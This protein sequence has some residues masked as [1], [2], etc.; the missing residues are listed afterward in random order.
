MGNEVSIKLHAPHMIID[1][2][3]GNGVVLNDAFMGNEVVLTAER[4]GLQ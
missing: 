3:K 1:A 4:K 2:F